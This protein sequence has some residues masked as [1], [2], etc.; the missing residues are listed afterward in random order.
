MEAVL[1]QKKR[2]RS[3]VVA[4][5]YYPEERN[6]ILDYFN[7]FGLAEGNGGLARAIIAPHGAWDFSGE[8]AGKAFSAAMGRNSVKNVVILGPIHDKREKGI[9]LSNSH[10]FHTPLG[11]IPVDKQISIELKKHGKNIEI[12]DIPHLAEHSIEILLPFVKY[13]FPQAS[14]VP[15]LMGQPEAEYISDLAH[16]MKTV[17]TPIINETL[18][19]VSCNLSCYNDTAT[20]RLSAEECLRLFSEKNAPALSSAIMDGSINP[21]GGALVV[22]L[23]ESGLLD[24]KHPRSASK[25]MASAVGIENDTVF[26]SAFFFE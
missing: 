22:S 17:I 2:I 9:F 6:E 20:A 8:L 16:A 3:P 1:A 5:M 18:L 23:I 21:C 7:S 12:N 26:Y 14:I 19:V 15:I 4:G 13:C 25:S 10:S 11:N 24:G